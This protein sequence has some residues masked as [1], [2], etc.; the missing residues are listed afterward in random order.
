MK[1]IIHLCAAHRSGRPVQLAVEREFDQLCF[2]ARKRAD[3]SRVASRA[4]ERHVRH[5]RQND[6]QHFHG[7]SPAWVRHRTL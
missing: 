3:R 1:K 6:G 7:L 4:E 2:I 5:E